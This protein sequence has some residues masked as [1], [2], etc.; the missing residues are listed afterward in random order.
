MIRTSTPRAGVGLLAIDAPPRNYGT[1][2]LLDALAGGLAEIESGDARV[3]VIASDVPGYFMAGAWLRDVIDAYRDPG[4]ARGDGRVWRRLTDRLERGPLVSIAANHGHA[5]GGGAELSWACNL[6][7]AAPGA[8]YAQIE[9]LLGTVPGGGGTVRLARLAGQSK[10]LELCLTGEPASAAEL[11]ALGV[12]NRLF[13]PDE[14]RERT[15]DWA[16]LIASRPRRGLQAIK[17]AILHGWDMHR[18]DALR[19][20]GYVFNATLDDEALARFERAQRG[21]E[22]GRDVWTTFASED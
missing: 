12:V 14:L 4:S 2:E 16:E 11:A 6:R 21:Y 10:A 3:V 13:E 7:T 8:T 5:W 19:L 18:D 17:R 22:A 15:L 20:E 1:F 9:S